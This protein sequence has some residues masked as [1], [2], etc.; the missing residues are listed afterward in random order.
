MCFTVNSEDKKFSVQSL[1][2]SSLAEWSLTLAQTWK[3]FV[4]F[5]ITS[6]F[7]LL[8]FKDFKVDVFSGLRPERPSSFL[9]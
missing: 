7:V 4:L 5:I 9:N 6:V 2:I 1:S 3:L 8:S